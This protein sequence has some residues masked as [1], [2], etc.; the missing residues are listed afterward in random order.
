MNNLVF[1]KN[2]ATLT[3]SLLVADKFEKNHRDVL[4]SIRVLLSTAENSA[5]LSMFMESSYIASNGKQNPMFIMNRDGFNLLTMGFTGK[6]ALDFKLEYIEA[7]N[8]MERQLKELQAS[9]EFK[10]PQSFS[11]ALRLAAE[12]AE[13]IESQQ[14][15]IES[16]KPRVLFSTAVETAKSSSLIGELAKILNQN[17]IQI[18]QKRLFEWLRENGYLIKQK[19][20]GYND[21]TQKAMDLGLF[22]IKKRTIENPDGVVLVTKTTKVT[23]KGQIYFVNKF[24]NKKVEQL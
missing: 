16:D 11:E 9:P 3:N 19:G 18:G 8:K 23:G 20:D 17:G 7:F 6:K 15:K 14:R 24:L 13:I 21:P 10:I 4:E 22:E 12:Q 2:G 5:L 1:N